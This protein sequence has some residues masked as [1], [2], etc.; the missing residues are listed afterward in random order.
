MFDGGG[1]W[2]EIEEG[3]ARVA[4]EYFQ[5]LFTASNPSTIEPM[6]EK[7]DRV[8]TPLMNHQLLQPYTKE[9]VK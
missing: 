2:H 7:V 4:K 9:E 5:E 1:Q 6:V 8:V 3:I